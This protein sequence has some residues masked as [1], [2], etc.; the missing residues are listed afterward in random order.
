VVSWSV[1]QDSVRTPK[2]IQG[3]YSITAAG[4]G[5]CDGGQST[6]TLTSG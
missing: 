3:V 6:E 2:Q 4:T 1:G 5:S